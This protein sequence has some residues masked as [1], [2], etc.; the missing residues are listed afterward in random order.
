MIL[1][2]Y[3]EIMN[4]DVTDFS[5]CTNKVALYNKRVKD[6]KENLGLVNSLIAQFKEEKRKHQN[7]LDERQ[8]KLKQYKE[9]AKKAYEAGNIE[10]E[11]KAKR[12]ISKML[13]LQ[14]LYD[15]SIDYYDSHLDLLERAHEKLIK[16]AKK[17]KEM[18]VTISNQY[19][20]I[21]KTV[22]G[23]QDSD[24]LEEKKEP[25]FSVYT[26]MIID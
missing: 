20:G 1:Q 6:V 9:V 8:K 18:E 22:S 23:Q 24:V 17:L 16:D 21:P 13:S 2:R 12:E 14:F 15:E 10:D 25:N 3:K 7:F 19:T 26:T 5:K 4:V 11:R